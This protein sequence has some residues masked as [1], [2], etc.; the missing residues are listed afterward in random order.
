M[1]VFQKYLRHGIWCA[2]LTNKFLGKN[3]DSS[4]LVEARSLEYAKAR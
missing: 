3:S 1:K 2:V 4:E